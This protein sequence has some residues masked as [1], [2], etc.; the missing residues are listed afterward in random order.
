LTQPANVAVILTRYGCAEACVTAGILLEV[1]E[2]YAR[3]GYPVEWLKQRIGD[4]F[5]AEVLSLALMAAERRADD[6]GT[7]LSVEERHDDV[8]RRLTNVTDDG[9]WLVAAAVLHAAGSLLADLR[10]TVEPQS[11]WGRLSLGRERTVTG[12]RRVHDRLKAIGF[13]AP[14]LGELDETIRS[15]EDYAD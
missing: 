12:F 5:G 9:R 1:V 2:D 6:E 14:I 13:A 8:L 4:K 10:R 7:E 15:L 3:E 11:V